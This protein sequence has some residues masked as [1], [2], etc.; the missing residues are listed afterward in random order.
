MSECVSVCQ[1]VSEFMSGCVRIC[2]RMCQNVSECVHGGRNWGPGTPL[3]VPDFASGGPRFLGGSQNGPPL[4]GGTPTGVLFYNQ[5]GV[6][7]QGLFL[8]KISLGNVK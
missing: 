2:V 6:L 3:G 5:I 1:C 7:E 4:G 8:L